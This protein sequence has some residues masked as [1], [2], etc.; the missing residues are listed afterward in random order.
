M[1]RRFTLLLWIL[2]VGTV[3]PWAETLFV[4]NADKAREEASFGTKSLIRRAHE[5]MAEMRQARLDSLREQMLDEVTSYIKKVAPTSYEALPACMV[6][7]CL[8][9]ELDLC[10]M[11]SQTQL[12]TCFGTQGMGRATSRYSMFGVS[13][14]YTSYENCIADYVALL[15][16]NYLVNGRTEQDLMKNYVNGGGFR[17]ASSPTYEEELSATYKRVVKST[18][19][20]DLQR[21]YAAL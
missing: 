12:E 19:I 6:E 8:E 5:Q 10:F 14:R 7:Q 4:M 3:A 2:I 15:K 16:S 20:R 18:N 9:N 17:Y 13:R 11:L 21:Q 1:K